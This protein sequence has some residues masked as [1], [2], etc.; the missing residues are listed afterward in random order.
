MPAPH[1]AL[2]A[3]VESWNAGDLDGYLRLYDE[4]IRLHGYSPEPMDKAQVRGFYEGIFSA[5]GTPKLRFDEILWDGDACTIRFTMTGRHVQEFMGVPATG[6]TITLPGI[7]IL[8][9]HGDKVAERFSQADMLGLLMQIGAI[10]A[11]A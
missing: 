2:S 3:A 5:F 11:P 10:P 1:E 8:H 7:T 4:G 6:T 9:F